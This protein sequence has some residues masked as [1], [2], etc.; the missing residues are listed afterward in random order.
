MPQLDVGHVG[1][2]PSE[3]G[4]GPAEAG[5]GDARSALG[6][7]EVAFA[8]GGVGV[9]TGS[10]PIADVAHVV[11]HRRAERPRP[12]AAAHPHM[13]AEIEVPMVDVLAT[14]KMLLEYQ[15]RA[16]DWL[17][18]QVEWNRKVMAGTEDADDSDQEEI[19]FDKR[20]LNQLLEFMPHMVRHLRAM[21]WTLEA[22][23]RDSRG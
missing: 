1:Y 11:R 19:L 21:V 4:L 23:E 10:E 8:G 5:G 2:H 14:A 22:M 17:K 15:T 7:G 9:G 3:G 16:S 12:E 18:Q 13:P 6:P 20:P